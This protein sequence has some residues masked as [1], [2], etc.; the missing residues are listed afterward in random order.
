MNGIARAFD[1]RR[2]LVEIFQHYVRR[3]GLRT[4]RRFLAEAE[5]TFERLARSPGIGSLY[6]PE[7]PG[8]ADLRFFPVSRYRSYLVFY[9]PTPD[10]VEI[11]RVLHGA[12]NLPGL[13][14]GDDEGDDD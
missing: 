7:A 1:A 13:L 10:G 8:L 14:G 11:V 12:R 3:A 2:D 5:A 6:D 4:A 9:R